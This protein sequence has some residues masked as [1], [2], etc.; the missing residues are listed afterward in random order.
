MAPTMCDGSRWSNGKPYP[1]RL[2]A[3]VVARNTAVE[4]LCLF[5]ASSPR[6]TTSPDAIPTRLRTT[7]T[8]V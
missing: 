5:P 8:N 3:A 6:S 2:V 4:A 7:C 1:V